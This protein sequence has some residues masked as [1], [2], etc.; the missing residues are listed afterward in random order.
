M[1]RRS[2]P[3]AERAPR[4]VLL[5]ILA[6]GAFTTALNVT[7]L[8]P[9]LTSIASDLGVGAPT[10]G[11]LA[12]LTAGSSGV[13]ALVVAPWMDRFSRA[14]WI[15]LECGLLTAGSILSATAPS[16]GWLFV[17]RALAGIGGAVIGASCLAAV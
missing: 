6:L 14:T 1:A 3:V 13:M 11:Q 8:S 17:G 12:T 2:A 16:F 4:R 7:L 10:A 9:L 5:G 15:R